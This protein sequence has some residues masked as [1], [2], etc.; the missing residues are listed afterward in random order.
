MT[1]SD[2]QFDQKFL[3]HLFADNSQNKSLK[4][5]NLADHYI[6]QLNEI[7][8]RFTIVHP[9]KSLNMFLEKILEKI[10]Q[11]YATCFV[12][13]FFTLNNFSHVQQSIY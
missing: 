4:S 10:L 2:L 8:N 9:Q 1:N 12:P 3:M 13:T 6:I 5:V 11:Y 7:K